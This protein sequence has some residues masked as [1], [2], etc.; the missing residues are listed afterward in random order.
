[1]A[2]TLSAFFGRLRRIRLVIFPVLTAVFSL[3]IS[4]MEA[5]R[6]NTG[7]DAL[8][9]SG[10]HIR[11]EKNRLKE[12]RCARTARRVLSTAGFVGEFRDVRL[13]Q[14]GCTGRGLLDNRAFKTEGTSLPKQETN[15]LHDNGRGI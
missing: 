3:E 13:H 2:D 6:W 9:L 11:T 14:G 10:I 5:L 1:M 12:H 8:H 15:S 4:A 7:I